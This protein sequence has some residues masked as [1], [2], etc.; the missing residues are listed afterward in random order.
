MYTKTKYF[1]NHYTSVFTWHGLDGLWH[2]EK[3]WFTNDDVL[4]RVKELY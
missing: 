2:A 3:H 1:K 4:F